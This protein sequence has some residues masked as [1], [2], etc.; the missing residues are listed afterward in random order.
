V[1]RRNPRRQRGPERAHRRGRPVQEPLRAPAPGDAGSALGAALAVANE[2]EKPP[3]RALANAFLGERPAG[4]GIGGRRSRANRISSSAWRP[5]SPR[6]LR[7][8]GARALR[9]G[10]ALSD[11]ARS[12]RT[13]CARGSASTSP[14]A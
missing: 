7:R 13:R 2:L 11:T 9:V 12:S 3:R 14:R 8:L 4:G 5:R 10:N 6:R 1:P